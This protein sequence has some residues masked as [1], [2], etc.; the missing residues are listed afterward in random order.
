MIKPHQNQQPQNSPSQVPAQQFFQ[1]PN[2]CQQQLGQNQQQARPAPQGGCYRCGSHEHY[3]SICPKPSKAQALVKEAEMNLDI[4]DFHNAEINY[5]KA[6]YIHQ[7]EDRSSEKLR[8]D[9]L[10]AMYDIARRIRAYHAEQKKSA[11]PPPV[12]LPVLHTECYDQSVPNAPAQDLMIFNENQPGNND[13]NVSPQQD[14][15]SGV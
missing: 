6:L 2:Q 11:T 10:A 3:A 4:K 14:F 13:K 8:S 15:L 5:E 1:A 7:N 9:D 12:T